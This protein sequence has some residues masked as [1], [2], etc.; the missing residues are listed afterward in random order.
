MYF[1][2]EKTDV[3]MCQKADKIRFLIKP[4]ERMIFYIFVEHRTKKH[5]NECIKF[6]LYILNAYS[7]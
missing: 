3:F 6:S 1:Y 7:T 5:F 2:K 4:E